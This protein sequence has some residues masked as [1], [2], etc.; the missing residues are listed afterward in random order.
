M[1]AFSR[2]DRGFF[3]MGNVDG[4]FDTGLAD[5]DYCDLISEC[6][7]TVTVSGGR[8]HIKPHSGEE[9]VHDGRNQGVMQWSYQ[10]LF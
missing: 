5:G 10:L 4:D 8:A 1:L 7:Q 2:G 3:A 9:P 6:Q